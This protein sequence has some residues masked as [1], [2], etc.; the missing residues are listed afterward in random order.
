MDPIC[1]DLEAEHEALDVLVR[2]LPDEA[3]DR[4]T[5][6]E[7]WM[8]R[9]QISHLWFFDGTARL[10]VVDVDAFQASAK[11]L[12]ARVDAG[13]DPSIAPG[14]EVRSCAAPGFVARG[15]GRAARRTPG[16]RPQGSHPL[17]RA[18]HGGALVRHGAADGD[19]GPRP[20][21]R[22]RARR[23]QGAHHAPATRRP[24]RRPGA[25][26]RLRHP[27]HAGDPSGRCAWSSPRPTAR[28]GRG[29]RTSATDVVQ[30]DALDFCLVV[31]QR[32][33]PADTALRRRGTRGRGVDGHRPGLRRAARP[34]PSAGPVRL[35]TPE[36]PDASDASDVRRPSV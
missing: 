35:L 26:V 20:G 4:L 3:W 6:A 11:A 28:R 33:H 8:V 2:D 16:D 22:R 17:V 7:G 10:A 32:R 21:C 19:V 29:D 9:D 27:R 24:H 18:D 1:D 30:G 12:L 14:R 36:A 23:D 34:G 31:T 25:P 13:D 5:P 15:S